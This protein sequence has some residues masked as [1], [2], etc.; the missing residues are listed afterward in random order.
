MKLT[1]RLSAFFLASLAIVLV[2]FSVA[3]FVSARIY[4]HRQVDDRLASALAVLSAAAEVH[5][6]GVE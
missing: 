4:L 1:T 5:P 6:D 3:L 2:G